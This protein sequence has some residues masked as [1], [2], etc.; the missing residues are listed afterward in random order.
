MNLANFIIAGTEKAGTTSVYT[1]LAQH[2]QV[3]ASR[4]KETDFFRQEFTDAQSYARHFPET[5]ADVIMEASPGY[6][7]DA[8]TVVPRM[9]ALVPDVKLLFIL[10]NPV[11]RFQSSFHFHR[12][13]LDLPESL[14]FH[15][16]LRSCID[17][18]RG[19]RP[20]SD[21]DTWYLKV[22]QFGCY[23]RYLRRYFDAFPR[24]RIR[25]A[26]YEDLQ[27][28]PGAFM[29][30]L[31][32]FLEIDTGY[33]TTADFAPVNVTF[34][35]RSKLVH[36]AAVV[37]NERLEPWLR[38]RPQLKSVVVSLYKRVN[39]ARHG[40]A[41]MNEADRGTLEAF[42]APW[43]TDLGKLLEI[44]LPEGWK[45]GE[46]VPAPLKVWAADQPGVPS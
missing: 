21:I 41:A 20:A 25:V 34:S 35:G 9:R 36:R 42:Y 13:R 4:R 15:D 18:S 23:A 29:V 33:W 16:Y 44:D 27:A 45:V 31:S 2:P 8:E 1:Y 26:F 3:V 32:E 30:S 40:Y 12:G 10:R 46:S 28:D 6:L 11:D 14:S 19:I 43:N 37:V 24:D 17:Y 39:R 5:A 7:G 22:L 38:P